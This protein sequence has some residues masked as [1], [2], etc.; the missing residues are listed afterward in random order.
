MT[1]TPMNELSPEATKKIRLQADLVAL[2]RFRQ[3]WRQSGCVECP[4]VELFPGSQ[5]LNRLKGRVASYCCELEG[6]E[7]NDDEILNSE[8]IKLNELDKAKIRMFKVSF[9]ALGGVKEQWHW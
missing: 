8:D 6:R 5:V 1:L 3:L 7:L 2:K 4:R 9:S